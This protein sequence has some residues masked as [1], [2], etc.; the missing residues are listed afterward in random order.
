MAD[1]IAVILTTE[2]ITYIFIH[3]T[4]F[5]PE[6][7]EI[8]K[9]LGD[10]Q[11]P[12]LGRARNVEALDKLFTKYIYL[13]ILSFVV[14]CL[15][16]FV[17]YITDQ[18]EPDEVS[19]CGFIFTPYLPYIDI[20]NQPWRSIALVCQCLSSYTAG[21]IAMCNISQFVFLNEVLILRYSHLESIVQRIPKV[22]KWERRAL[23]G[24]I[25]RYH[26]ILME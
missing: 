2:T 24:R 7:D 23:I 25:V 9:K 4:T 11:D 18:C 16:T 3:F 10:F 6:L 15:I 5:S 26:N 17:F 19:N 8:C 20:Y 1:D 12:D 13:C 14:T 21:A 22:K